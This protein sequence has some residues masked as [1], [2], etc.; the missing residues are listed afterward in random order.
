METYSLSQSDMEK[1]TLAI[2]YEFSFNLIFLNDL[3]LTTNFSLNVK[4]NN[5]SPFRPTI[6]HPTQSD[7]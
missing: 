7:Q 3:L 2:E 6:L 1:Q 5:M 4:N